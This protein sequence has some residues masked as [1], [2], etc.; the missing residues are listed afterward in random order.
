MRVIKIHRYKCEEIPNKSIT[1]LEDS[2]G[3]FYIAKL[4]FNQDNIWPNIEMIEMFLGLK[5]EPYDIKEV[6]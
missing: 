2:D 4:P 5:L 3:W 1:I 6:E